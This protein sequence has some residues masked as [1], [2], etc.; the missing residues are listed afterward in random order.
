MLTLH[1]ATSSVSS[2]KVRLVLSEKAIAWRGEVLDLQRGD[3]HRPDYRALNPSGVVPTLVDDG[4]V[5]VESTII[6]EYLED[7]CAASP[8]LMP[9]DPYA[10]ATVRHWLRRVD[11]LHLSCATVTFAL[12][13][14][15]VLASKTPE[16]LE[17][18]FAGMSEPGTR[19]RIL[20]AVA[21]G[22][23]APH[24]AYALRR[25]DKLL[26][27][28]DTA[29]AHAEHLAGDVYS[30]ADAALTPYVLRARMLGLDGLWVDRRPNLTRW[31]DAVRARASFDEAVESVLT[32]ADRKRL[33]VSREEIWPRASEIL[34]SA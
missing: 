8:R 9:A 26:G 5:I 2:A 29:L 27:D 3:Q 22:L 13:F 33:T 19:E 15:R 34:A 10:R 16:E 4:R 25:Y 31:F 1:H 24:A 14:R 28:V 18:R 17:A 6:M 30:L 21:K 23:D 11:D 12:A 20:Q 7:T 32:D